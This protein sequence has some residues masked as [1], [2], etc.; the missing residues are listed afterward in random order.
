MSGV[1]PISGRLAEMT[2]LGMIGK[3]AHRFPKAVM[4][5]H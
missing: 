3:I 2:A 4:L 5:E 1:C